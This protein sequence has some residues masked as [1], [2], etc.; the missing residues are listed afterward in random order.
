MASSTRRRGSR[1]RFSRSEPSA[2]EDPEI[3][4]ND[5]EESGGENASPQ[6]EGSAASSILTPNTQLEQ[7]ER[8]IQ[9]RRKGKQPVG[10]DAGETPGP[11]LLPES[12][13]LSTEKGTSQYEAQLAEVIRQEQQLLQQIKLAEASVRVAQLQ[14]KLHSIATPLRVR[15]GTQVAESIEPVGGPNK[16]ARGRPVGVAGRVADL[17]ESLDRITL[18]SPGDSQQAS[19]RAS[20]RIAPSERRKRDSSS[21]EGTS[22]RRRH[23][24]MKPKEPS[25]YAAKN[26]REHNEW[27]LDVENVFTIMHHEYRHNADKVAYAQQ[28]LRGDHRTTWN[29]HLEASERAV[30]F[31]EFCEVLLDMLQNPILRTYTTVRRYLATQ[32][33]QDQSVMSFVA[34]LDTLEGEMLPYTDDQRRM[35]LLCKL[36]QDLQQA[37]LQHGEAPPTRDELIT[38]AVRLEDVKKMTKDDL[39]RKAKAEEERLSPRKRRLHRKRR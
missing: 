11:P 1:G 29:R 26:L 6:R 19:T 8:G 34:Y 3:L 31:S 13:T 28:F 32:Q 23:Y 21:S 27:L 10:Q 25:V 24:G 4:E 36:R 33:Q 22:K 15:E 39:A 14:N 16:L 5:P 30:T 37:V 35:H 38:L 12:S 20:S 2:V 7:E 9:A 18:Q 17:Q